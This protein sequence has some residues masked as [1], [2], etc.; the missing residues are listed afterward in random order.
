[1]HQGRTQSLSYISII[2]AIS[3]NMMLHGTM[4]PSKKLVCFALFEKTTYANK[5]RQLLPG[6]GIAILGVMEP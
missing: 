1:V 4:C 6:I 3:V 5:A 2:V